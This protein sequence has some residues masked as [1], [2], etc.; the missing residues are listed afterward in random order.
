MA[1]S[2][3][4]SALWPPETMA[5]FVWPGVWPGVDMAL[6]SSVRACSPV[7]RS[8]TPSFSSGLRVSSQNVIGNCSWNSGFPN[9]SQSAWLMTYLALGNGHPGTTPPQVPADVVWM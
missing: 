3:I 8:R 4:T 7:I 9:V 6:I 5:R 2:P 1:T